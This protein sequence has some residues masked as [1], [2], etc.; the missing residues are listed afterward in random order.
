MHR[1]DLA[2]EANMMSSKGVHTSV[3]TKQIRYSVM[4]IESSA[5]CIPVPRHTQRRN[6]TGA[7]TRTRKAQPVSTTLYHR[8]HGSR[9]F[10]FST[11]AHA[12]RAR[13]RV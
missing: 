12:V 4:S 3:Q 2:C 9:L 13:N 11:R 6:R 8:Q 10:P 7:G 5:R 1:T